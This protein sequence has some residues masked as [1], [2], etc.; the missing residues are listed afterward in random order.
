MN[1]DADMECFW[2]T[3]VSSLSR[4]PGTGWNV[5][6]VESKLG[7]PKNIILELQCD[8]HSVKGSAAPF[9]FPTVARISYGLENYLKTTGDQAN[10]TAE[11]LRVFSATILDVV[12]A[13]EGPDDDLKK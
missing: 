1:N 10:I 3:C 2:L 8:I 13:D 5:S 4:K 9:G 7:K 6:R 12:D 11:D